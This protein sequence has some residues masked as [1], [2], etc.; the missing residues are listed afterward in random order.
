MTQEELQEIFDRVERVARDACGTGNDD[1]DEVLLYDAPQLAAELTKVLATASV[2]RVFLEGSLPDVASD[3]D[4][5]TLA[6]RVIER[7]TRDVVRLDQETERLKAEVASLKKD[8]DELLAANM[9]LRQHADQL[10]SDVRSL[11]EENGELE[12]ELE[13]LM[14]KAAKKKGKK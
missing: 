8:N 4:L 6:R 12:G 3:T 7:N 5:A 2:T 9:N 1:C 11:L 10:A 14:N 13:T